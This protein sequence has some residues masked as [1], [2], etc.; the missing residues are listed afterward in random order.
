MGEPELNKKY[1]ENGFTLLE[2]LIAMII[3]S[4]ALIGLLRGIIEY[5]KFTIQAKMKDRATEVL[6]SLTG[7][8]EAL[9]YVQDGSG[10]DSI[11]YANNENWKNTT[12][13]HNSC[14]IVESEEF[15]NIGTLNYSNPVDGISENLRLY[16]ET[17][18]ITPTCACRGER[19]PSSLPPCVYEGVAGKRIYA[20]VNVARVVISGKEQGKIA[21]VIV[22]YFE[23]FTNKYQQLSSVVIK[24][25]K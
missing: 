25:V 9:P 8:I 24:E 13:D 6:K 2:L 21:A 4:I 10:V 7:Y 19:C 18:Q 17:D 16:P 22:W 20:G 12:C 5:N 14:T 11:L 15:Y 23:P 3:M 1:S